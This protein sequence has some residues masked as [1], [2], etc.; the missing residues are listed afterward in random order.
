MGLAL[1]PK[2][3]QSLRGA[4]ALRTCN[5]RFIVGMTDDTQ[6]FYVVTYHLVAVTALVVHRFIRK[7]FEELY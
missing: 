4:E 6:K 3:R 5:F 7:L 1:R 2:K